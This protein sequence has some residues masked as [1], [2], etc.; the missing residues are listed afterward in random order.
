MTQLNT[1]LER[2]G[3]NRVPPP[4]I[5]NGSGSV[6]VFFTQFEAYCTSIY[7]TE[8][9]SW[10]IILPSFMDGEPRRIVQSFGSGTHITYENV[11]ARVQ[12]E[13]ERRT[14]GTNT[15]TDFYGAT[16]RSNESLLCYSIRL[17]SLA[18]RL[19]DTPLA[20][21]DLMVKT[22]FIS[23]LKP[24]TVTQISIR[25][26][27]DDVEFEE[28]VRL[29]QLLE[30][31]TSSPQEFAPMIEP[32]AVAPPP[33]PSNFV[34]SHSNN[35]NRNLRRN[36]AVVSGANVAPIGAS[37]SHAATSTC[38]NCGEVGHFSRQCPSNNARCYECGERG[39]FGRECDIRR[40]RQQQGFGASSS[41][42]GSRQGG[43]N[44][45]GGGMSN[46]NQRGNNNQRGNFNQRGHRGGRVGQGGSNENNRSNPSCAY[47]GGDHLIKDCHQFQA[48]VAQKCVWCGEATH[49]SFEC[50]R[51]P[52][53]N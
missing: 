11:K 32:P 34:P 22:K 48:A 33:P 45:T 52:S 26:G 17:Q 53:G 51:R 24:S 47:C 28:I 50:E 36:V 18:G 46:A 10:L 27:N 43:F 6:A 2:L 37:A 19:T 7:G 23:C 29:S 31:E 42:R 1:A 8:H 41:A 16:R 39:H 14:L 20:H 15:I 44:N 9:A 21:R 38:F 25:Y 35:L 12:T 13:L 30:N 40:A 49:A 4:P 5:Y 3:A